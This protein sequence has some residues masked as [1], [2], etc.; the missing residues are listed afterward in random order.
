MPDD[1]LDDRI[2]E[3]FAELDA[4]APPAPPRPAIDVPSPSRWLRVALPAVATA[5]VVLVA[6]AV[7]VLTP[8]QDSGDASAETTTTV[9][10][11]PETT[12]SMS[13]AET[14]T[15]VAADNPD[16]FVALELGRLCRNLSDSIT[17]AGVFE[18]VEAGMYSA[19]F[20]TTVEPIEQFLAY[21]RDLENVRD[22]EIR[23]RYPRMSD[24]LDQ[25]NTLIID[26]ESKPYD[27]LVSALEDFGMIASDELDVQDC[28]AIAPPSGS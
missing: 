25:I 9:M 5:A 14:T 17:E 28:H 12:T 15:S 18:L 8:G 13:A 6:A 10:A 16:A 27:A 11:A 19:A 24:A 3:L 7:V 26:N 1:R 4:A 20:D 21:V 2:R 23:E 22:L